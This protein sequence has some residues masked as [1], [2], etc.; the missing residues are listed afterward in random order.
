MKKMVMLLPLFVFTSIGYAEQTQPI[1]TSVLPEQNVQS[2]LWMQNAGEYRALCY[3]AYNMAKLAFAAAKA[4]QSEAQSGK[5]LAVMVDLDETMIDNSP[6]AAWQINNQ[7]GYQ[8]DTWNAWVNAVQTPAID[9]AVALANYITDNGGTMFYV[10]NRSVRTQ[11]ATK[12]NLEQLGF[13]NVSDF[14]V[15]LKQD[16]S[17]KASRLA[18]IEADGYEV[19]VL[20]G[21]NLNDFPELQTYHTLNTQRKQIVDAHQAEFGHRF[22]LLPNPS[23]GDWEPGLGENYYRLSETEKLKLRQQSL[24]SWSPQ[25]Q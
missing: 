4:E 22:I 16:S 13:P 3:Q 8:T 12:K 10:S 1:N 2:V 23:Y 6:Y 24:R 9:G 18:S 20:M 25:P 15:R 19:V 5:K 17:N 14:T 7:Q 21:D 11:A